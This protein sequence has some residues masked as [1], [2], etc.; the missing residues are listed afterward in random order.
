MLYQWRG[1]GAAGHLKTL[2]S[3]A[4]R[5]VSLALGD[6]A[7]ADDKIALGFDALTGP[8]VGKD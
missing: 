6:I 1:L 3:N 2:R 8:H 4:L 5:D 7:L